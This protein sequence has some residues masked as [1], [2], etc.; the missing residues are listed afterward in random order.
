MPQLARLQKH[1][2]L[3]ITRV[4]R[5][6]ERRWRV[7]DRRQAARRRRLERAVYENTQG[8]VAGG[9]FEGLEFVPHAVWGSCAPMLAGT[10]EAEV[11]SAIERLIAR[12]PARVL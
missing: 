7:R 9:P 10:Y 4:V 6:V 3:P 8:R 12:R 2:R 11:E 1:A 5:R